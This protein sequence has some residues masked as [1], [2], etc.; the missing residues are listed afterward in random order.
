VACHVAAPGWR[1]LD[2]AHGFT[3]PDLLDLASWHETIADPDPARPGYA[4]SSTPT[5]PPGAPDGPWPTAAGFPPRH[6]RWAG[7]G[8][9][10]ATAEGT[11]WPPSWTRGTGGA[12]K[13][14]AGATTSRSRASLCSVE[15]GRR[16][17]S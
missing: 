3:R 11:I 7:T 13:A 1:L 8:C 2:V 16:S 4:P 6:G 14:G 17:R 5:R 10:A 12:M 15:E 9:V